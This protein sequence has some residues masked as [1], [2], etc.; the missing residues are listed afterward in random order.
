MPSPETQSNDL[1][2]T[3]SSPP[4]EGD[5]PVP[6]PE[7]PA[8]PLDGSQSAYLGEADSNDFHESD[9]EANPEKYRH[10]ISDS[11]NAAFLGEADSDDAH[12]ADREANPEA[13]RHRIEDVGVSGAHGEAG[14]GDENIPRG[15]KGRRFVWVGKM[16]EGEEA[17]GGVERK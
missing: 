16:G 4:G 8:V 7:R 13:Y 17:V 11:S 3:P 6:L 2:N 15:E 10:S 1:T 9:R 14:E 5:E 12:E